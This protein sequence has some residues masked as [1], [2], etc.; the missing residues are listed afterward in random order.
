MD[1]MK[2]YVD[3]C[4]IFLGSGFKR[5]MRLSNS[6]EIEN[7]CREKIPPIGELASAVK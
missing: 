5:M 4:Y 3:L 6:L 7:P 1:P 2:F